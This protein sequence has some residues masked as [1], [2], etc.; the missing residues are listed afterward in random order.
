M[1]KPAG[2]I[3]KDTASRH[4][5]TGTWYVRFKYPDPITGKRREK[6]TGGLSTQA[7]AKQVLADLMADHST[8]AVHADPGFTLRDGWVLYD[9][10]IENRLAVGRLKKNT[11]TLYRTS[12]RLYIEPLWGDRKMSEVRPIDIGRLFRAH[13]D[14]GLTAGSLNVAWHVARSCFDRAY[15]NGHTGSN[16]FTRVKKAD[17]LG[18]HVAVNK[19]RDKVWNREQLD[20]FRAAIAER[21]HPDRYIH[22]LILFTGLR[23]GEAMGVCDDA[24]DGGT[25]TR[26][27]T[28]QVRRQYTTGTDGSPFWDTPKTRSSNRTVVLTAEVVELSLIHI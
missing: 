1:H 27:A 14:T 10:E 23:R 18:D 13:L 26:P 19:A 11:A 12:W 3:T 22:E 21:D 8:G 5:P 16:P 28:L 2:T 20:R 4:G 7:D 17:I 24:L 25:A 15:R 9:E 6:V